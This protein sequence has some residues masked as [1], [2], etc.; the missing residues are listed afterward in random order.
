MKH[1]KQARVV[2]ARMEAKKQGL[3]FNLTVEAITW[4][5][6]CPILGVELFYGPAEGD[7]NR[8]ASLDRLIPELGYVIGNV[9]VISLKANRLKNNATLA[10]LKA[11]VRYVEAHQPE[12]TPCSLNQTVTP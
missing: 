10:E 12:D 5:T 1:P 3:P 8:S 7:R 9:F 2:S 4:P 6:H 11:L